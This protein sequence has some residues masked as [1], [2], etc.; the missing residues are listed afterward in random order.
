MQ[1]LRCKKRTSLF[2]LTLLGLAIAAGS[3]QATLLSDGSGGSQPA[4][5]ILYGGGS[6]VLRIE[7]NGPAEILEHY[8]IGL[9][10]MSRMTAAFNDPDYSIQALQADHVFIL[11]DLGAP[12]AGPIDL[13]LPES[14]QLGLFLL[15]DATLR[16]FSLG[17]NPYR[18]IFSVAGAPGSHL[19]GDLT[20]TNPNETLLSFQSFQSGSVGVGGGLVAPA[21]TA[22]TLDLGGDLTIRILNEDQGSLIDDNIRIPVVP[23]PA[24]LTLL[25]VGLALGGAIK[26]RRR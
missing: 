2:G 5:S 16:D 21:G 1:S 20:S 14:A 4:G 10:D 18:P 11:Q 3:A 8:T 25:G 15:R 7:I 13:Q 12:L 9:Y 26:R 6:S 24:T 23:E 17:L 22:G 19:L